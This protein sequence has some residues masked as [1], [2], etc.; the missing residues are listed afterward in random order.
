MID[1]TGE[2]IHPAV[3]AVVIHEGRILLILRAN[4][5]QKGKWAVPGGSVEKGETLQEAAER[6]VLEETGLIIS[7][8]DP[9]HTVEIIDRYPDGKIRFHYRVV[10]VMGEY[11]S[12]SLKAADDASETGWFS[13][14][15][16]EKIELTETMKTLLK[17]IKFI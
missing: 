4:P 13:M 16:L 6:E 7:A 2:Y 10:E 11:V 14:E 17:K 8:G 12:G 1:E 9:V 5:P 3:G 15:D